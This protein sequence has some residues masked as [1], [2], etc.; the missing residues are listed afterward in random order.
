MEMQFTRTL[1]DLLLKHV[2][3]IFALAI[4]FL[5]VSVYYFAKDALNKQ[6]DAQHVYVDHF[7]SLLSPFDSIKAISSNILAIKLVDE[8]GRQVN[9]KIYRKS[10]DATKYRFELDGVALEV[11]SRS[12]LS[13]YL[14]HWVM[15]NLSLIILFFLTLMLN[16]YHIYKHWKYL[17]QLETWAS[18]FAKNRKFKFYIKTRDYLLINSI[19][20]LNKERIEAKKGG[21]KADHFIRSQ[22]FLDT[23]TS[24]GNRL[25]FEHRLDSVLQHE[26]KVYG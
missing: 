24:L 18:R 26:D 14:G 22:T 7:R 2:F 19:R 9:S 12:V 1:Y 10:W 5:N 16:H 6:V 13:A 3:G 25:Y 8:G 15:M 4:I 17:I 21:Q 23:S 11:T 20:E